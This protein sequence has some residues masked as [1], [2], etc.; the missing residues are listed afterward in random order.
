V[1]GR[2]TSGIVAS[3]IARDLQRALAGLARQQDRLAT[4]RRIGAPSDDPLGVAQS[5]V[6]R[7]RQA[8]VEQFRGNVAEVR[9]RLGRADTTLAALVETVTR[10]KEAA[11]QGASG[12][13]DAGT[14]RILAAH[15]DQ[16]LEQMVALANTR[17][18]DDGFL[19]GGLESTTAP[20]G[21]TRGAD[22]RVIAVTV[23]P[24]G[25]DGENLAE[26]LDGV[27]VATG[28]SGALV[29]G[30]VGD[31]TRAFDA[32]MRLRD[33]LQANDAAGLQAALG[34]I[35]GVLDRPVAVSTLVG[36]RLGWL[37]LVDERLG[38]E[39]VALAARVSR[40]EDL[41]VAKA[42]LEFQ[43]QQTLHEAALAAAG[44]LLPLSLVNFLR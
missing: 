34:E 2:I 41:D 31:P 32:L 8:A 29:F 23:N 9:D 1:T 14:R 19:F 33:R 5:L 3:Q 16:L 37:D 21:V 25:I 15:V 22:G 42:V 17:G 36:S 20:Y 43:Q 30:E 7:S 27:T 13:S 35:D 18:A 24:R 11:I 40:L 4:G 38:G 26:I 39:T 28:V 12:T 6:T 10:A 44:R